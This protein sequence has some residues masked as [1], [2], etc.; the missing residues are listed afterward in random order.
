MGSML[1]CSIQIKY[2]LTVLTWTFTWPE[3]FYPLAPSDNN[4]ARIKILDATLFI[5]Q[6]ELKHPL[7]LAHA[8]VLAM[9][10]KAHYPLTHTQIKIFTA[11]SGAQQVSI[12]NAFFGLIREMFLIAFVKNKTFVGSASTNLFHFQHYD[13][14][15]LVLF[16]NGVQNPSEPLTIDCSSTFGATRA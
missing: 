6:A 8:N 16:V 2:Y 11:S 1:T 10:R 5:T 4:K 9:Q 7:L 15:N 12:D 3:S 13:M 14:S